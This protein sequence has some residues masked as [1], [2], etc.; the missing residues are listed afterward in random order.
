VVL[1]EELL[2]EDHLEMRIY[3]SSGKL[4]IND[5]V[6]LSSE[7]I[8]L[9]IPGVARGTYYLIIGGKNKYYSGSIIFN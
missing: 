3:D 5:R 6:E 7:K 9:N 2:H 8:S 1:P 4:I